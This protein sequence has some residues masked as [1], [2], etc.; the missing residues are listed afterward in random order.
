MS[1]A[2][3]NNSNKIL[4]NKH[5]SQN[6]TWILHFIMHSCLPFDSYIWGFFF[7]QKGVGRA[8]S[9]H[10]QLWCRLLWQE[11]EE[12]QIPTNGLTALS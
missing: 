9:L 2:I 5:N 7:L 3:V 8:S 12:T 4:L 6:N 11:L 1:G 10:Q